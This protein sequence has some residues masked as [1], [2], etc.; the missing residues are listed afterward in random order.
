MSDIYLKID[1]VDGDVTDDKYKKH[2]QVFSLD[3][4][5]TNPSSVS[6]GTQAGSAAGGGKV[7]LE[8]VTFEKV[9]DRATPHLTS[10]FF[11]GKHFKSFEFKYVISRGNS[12]DEFK[13]VK[14]TDVLVTG[15]HHTGEGDEPDDKA[16][17]KA[18]AGKGRSIGGLPREKISLNFARIELSYKPR[19]ADGGFDNALKSGYDVAAAKAI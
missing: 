4:G 10:H 15:F 9:L 13:T 11:Q 5:G 17:G 6:V 8:D 1:G 3:L 12:S 14:L 7:I 2:V 19:K 18:G 16:S